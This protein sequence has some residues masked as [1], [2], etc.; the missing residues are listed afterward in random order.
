MAK[1]TVGETVKLKSDSPR[2]TI[3]SIL[4]I[5]DPKLDPVLAEMLKQQ[6]S[7]STVF[8]MCSWFGDGNAF[9]QEIFPEET[10]LEAE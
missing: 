9:K 1:F 2:M 6:N 7:S 3:M 8:Y 4:D 10:L 5:N